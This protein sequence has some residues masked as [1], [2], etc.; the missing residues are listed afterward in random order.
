MNLVVFFLSIIPGFCFFVPECHFICHLNSDD[1][2]YLSTH[3]IKCIILNTS[4][5]FRFAATKLSADRRLSE[6][7]CKT[8]W[9]RHI[10]VLERRSR[11]TRNTGHARLCSPRSAELW[12]DRR[13]NRHVVSTFSNNSQTNSFF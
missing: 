8:V 9:L 11:R 1:I 12:T 7:W 6:L 10:Q 5:I 13:A 4:G 2:I 3:V